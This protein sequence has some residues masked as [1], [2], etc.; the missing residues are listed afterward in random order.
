M[1]TRRRSPTLFELQRCAKSAANQVECSTLVPEKV[2][3]AA[4]ASRPARCV[5]SEGDRA[6]AS[7]DDDTGLAGRCTC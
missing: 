5:A 7:D 6:R 3:P 1:K 2:A 4:G